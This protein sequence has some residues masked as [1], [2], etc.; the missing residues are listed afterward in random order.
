MHRTGATAS[1]KLLSNESEQVRQQHASSVWSLSLSNDDM[2]LYSGS[3]DA[4]VGVWD[5]RQPKVPVP[6]AFMAGHTVR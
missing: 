1:S 5:L 6:K 3:F 4:T 2:L